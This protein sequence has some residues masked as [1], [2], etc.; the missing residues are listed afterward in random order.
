MC[1]HVGPCRVYDAAGGMSRHQQSRLFHASGKML[2]IRRA[3]FR[4]AGRYAQSTL[5]S[6]AFVTAAA[7][8]ARVKDLAQAADR[9]TGQRWDSLDRWVMFSDLHVSTRTLN[10]C[11]D[12]LRKI[13]QEAEARQAGVLFLGMICN[14]TL[15]K[16]SA[17]RS[18]P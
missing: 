8:S 17:A 11:I 1:L 18:V 5:R 3:S 6:K 13:K 14:L 15:N 7:T 4:R 2:L 12:V 16:H 9:P 10:T